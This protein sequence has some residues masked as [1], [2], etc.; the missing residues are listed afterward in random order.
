MFLYTSVE[1]VYGRLW[2]ILLMSGRM[3]GDALANQ[4]HIEDLR[5]HHVIRLEPNQFL[6][7][8]IVDNDSVM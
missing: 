6:T 2:H 8:P 3:V 1:F 4:G 7:V 5:R